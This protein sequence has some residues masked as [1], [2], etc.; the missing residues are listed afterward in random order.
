MFSISVI[1]NQSWNYFLE[2][3]IYAAGI[4]ELVRFIKLVKRKEAKNL[5]AG[6]TLLIGLLY[7]GC[8][9]YFCLPISER[10]DALTNVLGMAWICSFLA[11]WIY[12]KDKHK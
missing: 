10:M 3:A 4:M 9:V 11:R 2:I 1:L 6:L 12:C 7:I 8:G 5:F